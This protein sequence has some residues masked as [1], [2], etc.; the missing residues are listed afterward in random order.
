MASA[1]DMVTS[2][3]LDV[4]PTGQT[5][6][7]WKGDVTV[8]GSLASFGPQGLLDRMA[9]ANVEKFVDGIKRGIAELT[10]QT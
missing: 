6:V 5:I 8:S 4:A 9:R 1:V 3:V 10:P 7:T 2:F